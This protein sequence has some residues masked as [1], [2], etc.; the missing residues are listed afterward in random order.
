[1]K[2]ARIFAT[3]LLSIFILIYTYETALGIELES[4]S[5]NVYI[6][7]ANKLTLQDIQKMP[8]LINLLDESGIGLMNVRGT[9]GYTGAEGFATINA[10]AKTYANNMSSQFHNLNWEYRDIYE[11]RVGKLNGQYSVGNIEL[12]RL[13]NQNE[14]NSYD[15]RIGLLGDILHENGLKTAVFGNSDTADHEYR[16]AALIPM[17]SKG[18]IDYGNVDNILVQDEDYPYGLKTDYNRILEEVNDIK[19]KASLIVID[20]GDLFRLHNES[21]TVSDDVFLEKRNKILAD[22]DS[23]IGKLIENINKESLLFILSP[24]SGEE[25]INGSRLTPVILWGSNVSKGLLISSTTNR[26]GII[27]NLD[28]APTVAEFFGLKISNASGNIIKWKDKGDA[29]QYIKS[30][31]SRIDLTSKTRSKSLTAYGIISIIVLSIAAFFILVKVRMDYNINR[32]LRILLLILYGIPLILIIS[33]M[34][35]IVSIGKFINTILLLIIIYA[36]L[37]TKYN[38]IKALYG[39]TYAYCIII[40]ADIAFDGLFSE[41]SVLSY[42][43]VIGARYFG[44]G[45]EMAGLF[46]AVSMTGIGLLY[47]KVKK[48]SLLGLMLALSVLLVG[49][50][51]LGANVGGMI[52]FLSASLFFILEVMEKKISLKNLI[53]IAFITVIAVGLLGLIDMRLNPNP[54]HL[55][56]TLLK[57]GEEGIDI[58]SNIIVR[59]IMMNIKLVGSSFWTKVLFSNIII[60]LIISCF[61]GDKYEKLE[62]MGF[63]KGFISCITGSIVGFLVNDS[64]LILSAIAIN[65]ITA[66]L[67][68]IFIEDSVTYSNRKWI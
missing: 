37:L 9:S 57:I 68:F 33:S 64:G 24:N 48:K 35:N 17:D 46:L 25:R 7:V 66:L 2:A 67:M 60:Q 4:Q 62:N 39:L 61:H 65:M 5:K 59:K 6:V 30:I 45:N 1:M 42:D 53:A 15:P 54:T 8:N 19:H 50:P 36:I 52:T 55:G 40:S 58:A 23:F 41:F 22:I 21:N 14:D 29:F 47:S 3:I 27:A 10:S 28:I 32:L 43:P 16:Y 12:G 18:L 34:F 51:K 20:T 11:N 31:N 63:N 44:I 26:L 13:Y 56:K 38:R 49:H